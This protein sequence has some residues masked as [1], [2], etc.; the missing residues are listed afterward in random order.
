MNIFKGQGYIVGKHKN[1]LII[2]DESFSHFWKTEDDKFLYNKSENVQIPN[3]NTNTSGRNF[4]DFN[5]RLPIESLDAII[6]GVPFSKGSLINESKVDFFPQ[7]LREYSINY[8][9]YINAENL[10][11][12]GIYDLSEKDFLFKNLKFGDLGNLELTSTQNLGQLNGLIRELMRYTLKNK[13]NTIAIGGDHSIT[14][15]FVSSLT[16]E[17]DRPVII[18]IFD[19]HHD[20]RNSL[21]TVEQNINHCN[22]VKHLLGLENVVKIIQIGVRG[23]RSY[24]QMLFHPKLIQISSRYVIY[25]DIQE[26]IKDILYQFPDAI[27]YLSVDLDAINPNEFSNVDFPVPDGLSSGSITHIIKNLFQS[28]L[29]ILGVDIVEGI[30]G[31]LRN[32]YCVPIQILA[33]CLN[34]IS[35][36]KQIK[37]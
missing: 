30:P 33:H 27:G 4:F 29:E 11:A 20:C 2:T 19:A 23:L 36:Q 7:Y 24:S 6:I 17:I 35:L 8:P 21:F 16:L 10:S 25:D 12:S 18:I 9:V 26:Q 3:I 32:D 22:F 5:C 15:S 14:Y 34:G 31:G 28:D 37:Q 13:I 1:D